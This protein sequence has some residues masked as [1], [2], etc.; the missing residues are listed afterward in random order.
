MTSGIFLEVNL[1]QYYDESRR[2]AA[3]NNIR[4]IFGINANILK[5][6]VLDNY[7]I[8]GEEGNRAS[9]PGIYQIIA[10][11]F[12]KLLSNLPY[13]DASGKT[14]VRGFMNRSGD[15]I[16]SFCFGIYRDG[17]L[18][19]MYRF[20]GGKQDGW[21]PTEVE[22][23]I[24][25]D[26]E[27]VYRLEMTSIE[28]GYHP[29]PAERAKNFLEQYKVMLGKKGFS[30]VFAATMP[31]ATF[32]EKRKIGMIRVM[33]GIKPQLLNMT[34]PLRTSTKDYYYGY[35]FGR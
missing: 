31:Y 19:R 24:G 6:D 2:Y 29:D 35:I 33:E 13:D 30:V 21:T 4:K 1:G 20:T 22:Y 11:K 23:S 28:H 32:L 27:D 14:V 17:M 3:R 5:K 8:S 16:R 12:G 25:M 34:A 7:I 10:N 9:H 26:N 15:L 18:R